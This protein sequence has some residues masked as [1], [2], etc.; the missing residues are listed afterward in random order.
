MGKRRRPI[1]HPSLVGRL[2]FLLRL[3][4]RCDRTLRSWKLGP[5]SASKGRLGHALDVKETPFTD[6]EDFIHPA[7]WKTPWC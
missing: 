2:S 3:T 6:A 7:A 1:C 5:L 4:S